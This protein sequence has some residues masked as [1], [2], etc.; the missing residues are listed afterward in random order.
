MVRALQVH[1]RSRS[2]RQTIQKSAPYEYPLLEAEMQEKL[3]ALFPEWDLTDIRPQ[4][5][6]GSELNQIVEYVIDNLRKF[7]RK[8]TQKRHVVEELEPVLVSIDDEYDGFCPN[9]KP[10]IKTNKLMD[11]M[12]DDALN[13]LEAQMQMRNQVF[14][15]DECTRML[16]QRFPGVRSILVEHLVNELNGSFYPAALVCFLISLRQLEGLRRFFLHVDSNEWFAMTSLMPPRRRRQNLFQPTN[17]KLKEQ[18]TRFDDFLR[19]IQNEYGAVFVNDDVN[20]MI[21]KPNAAEIEV[22]KSSFQCPV[23]FDEYPLESGVSCKAMIPINGPST[24]KSLETHRFCKQCIKGHAEAATTEIPLAT[25]A[26]GLKCMEHQCENPILFSEILTLLTTRVQKILNERIVEENLGLANLPNLE[27]CSKCNFA[28]IMEIP[29]EVN[30]VFKCLK[31][32]YQFCRF[33]DRPWNDDHFGLKCEEI[34]AKEKVDR[35]AREL[36]KRMNEAIVHK[37]HRCG[38]TF[39][40][41]DGCNKIACR[42][43]AAQCYVCREKNINYNHFCQ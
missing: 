42:C 30:K 15:P 43:G 1:G 23:C 22:Q 31:C 40:K 12:I 34:D 25:G 28:V 3:E 16:M 2:K 18:V 19:N 14:E 38:L 20:S 29:K 39:V 41:S 9:K 8:P 27:R 6:P 26:V 5:S 35:V 24:S 37:C 13:A 32:D 11:L 4:V 36:E 33:C 21:L 7:H 17:P 10:R